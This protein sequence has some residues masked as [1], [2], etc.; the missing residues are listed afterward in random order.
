MEWQA[1]KEDDD[2]DERREQIELR[3]DWTLA[4]G[5]VRFL[6]SLL[7]GDCNDDTIMYVDNDDIMIV[8]M[9]L[10]DWIAAWLNAGYWCSAPLIWIAHRA[11]FYADD[12]MFMLL[13]VMLS[14]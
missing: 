6:D 12:I 11:T 9:E 5:I 7:G 13:L 10:K 14:F 2:C 8:M 4:V 3:V 1:I